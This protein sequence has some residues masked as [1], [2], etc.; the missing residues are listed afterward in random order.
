MIYGYVERD[1]GERLFLIGIFLVVDVLLAFLAWKYSVSKLASAENRVVHTLEELSGFS[2]ESAAMDYEDVQG[3]VRKNVILKATWN[4]F[5]RSV[6]KQMN[7]DGRHEVFSVVDAG[8]IFSFSAVTKTMSISYW[9]NFGGIFTGV[10]IL[11]TFVGLV[12]GLNGVDLT[13]SDVTVLKEGIGNL[14]GGIS[15]AFATS[16]IGIFCALVYGGFHQQYLEKLQAAV[17]RFAA[18]IEELYPRRSAEWWLAESHRESEEQTKTLKNLSQD[19]AEQLA[20]LLQEQM[21]SGFSEL[22]ETLDQQMKP[23]FEKLYEELGKLSSGGASQIADVM[24][25]RAGAQLDAFAAA[26]QQIPQTVQENMDAARKLTEENNSALAVA[27]EEHNRALTATMTEMKNVIT[28]GAADAAQVQS[29]AAQRM[30]ERIEQMG[31]ALRQ[32]TDGAAERLAGI[33]AEAERMQEQMGEMVQ[34]LRNVLEKHNVT[35]QN[36]YDKFA[37]IASGFNVLLTTAKESEEALQSAA[38]PLRDASSALRGELARMSEETQ[39]THD[40]IAEQMK[41]LAENGQRTEKNIS[42]L[43]KGMEKAEERTATAW[44]QYEAHFG[45]ISGELESATKVITERLSEYNTAMNEGMKKQLSMF[46]QYMGDAVGKLGSAITELNEL[47][48][49]LVGVKNKSGRN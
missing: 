8:D 39:K 27:M 29:D 12:V 2:Q 17:T 43:I 31:G 30:A 9:Q 1:E 49:D 44:G 10:G 24:S 4:D 15:L 7:T 11:G 41:S 33:T 28:V 16:L 45:K 19:M 5:D 42:T 20:P 6:V 36:T 34:H 38:K 14:L 40:E 37:E 25:A 23:L 46:D 47:V 22:C 32:S 13:S 18:R 35:M 48:E 26:L 3:I 21:N